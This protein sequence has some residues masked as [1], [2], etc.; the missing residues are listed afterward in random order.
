MF[1]RRHYI[2]IARVL[3]EAQQNPLIHQPTLG[4]IA[5]YMEEAFLA[6]NPRFDPLRFWA[7]AFHQ[8]T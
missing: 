8:E 3:H 4:R 1:T 5:L 2:A 7:A 6:D